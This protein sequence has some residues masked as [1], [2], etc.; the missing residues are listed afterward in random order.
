MLLSKLNSYVPELRLAKKFMR[1]RI[2]AF[3][4]FNLYFCNVDSQINS[5]EIWETAS[6]SLKFAFHENIYPLTPRSDRNLN[7]FT[8]SMK[9][10]TD[11]Y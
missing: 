11:C 7:L 6:V 4:T 10:Q 1:L 3:F 5:V 9:C 2:N 8:I